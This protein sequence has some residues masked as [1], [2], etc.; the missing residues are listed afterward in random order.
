MPA[1]SR[2]KRIVLNTWTEN[3][4]A[5]TAYHTLPKQTRKEPKVLAG[6]ICI[7]A[8]VS[9][10]QA[11]SAAFR[12]AY[13]VHPNGS[14]K[15]SMGMPAGEHLGETAGKHLK[16]AINALRHELAESKEAIPAFEPDGK[17]LVLHQD[18]IPNMH[19]SAIHSALT[20]LGFKF[21]YPHWKLPL[22]PK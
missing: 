1:K 19:Y 10:A 2:P 14:I 12:L 21:I 4:V 15:L 20:E 13:R 18:G 5:L 16:F 17:C 3:G 7:H 22:A 11:G 6:E 9:K 8:G